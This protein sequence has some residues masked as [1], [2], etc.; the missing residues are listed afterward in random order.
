MNTV[1]AADKK[2][3]TFVG[4]RATSDWKNIDKEWIQLYAGL[5][6]DDQ[7]IHVD[8]TYAKATPYGGIIAHGFLILG[9]L[10]AFSYELVPP[11]AGQVFA[12]NVG[13]ENLRNRNY[14]K[15]G[16]NV[17]AHFTLESYK[18]IGKR[19]RT[20]IAIEIE[21]EG[22]KKPALTCNWINMHYFA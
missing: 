19:F 14:V 13:V 22:E 3:K 21:I 17:R 2:F 7:P 12:M 9:L 1:E 11:F 6:G 20:N 10:P 4:V 18:K 16:S 8:E 15:A 5:M